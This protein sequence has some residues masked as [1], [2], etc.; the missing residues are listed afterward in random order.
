VSNQNSLLFNT[1]TGY[2]KPN[3]DWTASGF[4]G[5]DGVSKDFAL[6]MHFYINEL[7]AVGSLMPM[8][9]TGGVDAGYI[10]GVNS[11][12]KIEQQ[13]WKSSVKEVNTSVNTFPL[14]WNS[15]VI[16][17]INGVITLHT[18]NETTN[19]SA[20]IIGQPLTDELFLVHLG[21]I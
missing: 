3:S 1:A 2:F 19:I 8:F 12:G 21:N 16:Q 17:R 14:G 18:L 4:F 5:N 6:G 15:M 11:D 13:V 9:S 10:L 7:P 20:N